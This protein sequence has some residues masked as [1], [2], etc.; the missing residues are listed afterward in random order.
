MGPSSSSNS[1]DSVVRIVANI[2]ISF[3]GA[4]VL[5]LPYA[6]KEAGL[7]EGTLI[8]SV[9][10]YL[11]VRAMIMLIDCKYMV[12]DTMQVKSPLCLR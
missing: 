6:F 7:T 9:V 2:F 11:S 5:G 4:G 10:S 1:T 12:Q 3:I 8:M